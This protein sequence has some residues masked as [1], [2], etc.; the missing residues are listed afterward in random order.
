M[1]EPWMIPV[2]IVLIIVTGAVVI[3]VAYKVLESRRLGSDRELEA[4]RREHGQLRTR[5][6]ELEGLNRQLGMQVEWHVKM[7]ETG[8]NPA[9]HEMG[10]GRAPDG[11]S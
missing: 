5:V 7:L 1:F 8:A 3:S 6:S 4:L 2:Y 11:R 9:G 10:E